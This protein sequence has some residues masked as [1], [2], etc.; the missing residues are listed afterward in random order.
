VTNGA[1]SWLHATTARF[2]TPP[3]S[4]LHDSTPID[5]GQEIPQ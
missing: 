1:R 4:T 3:D 5:I 2:T